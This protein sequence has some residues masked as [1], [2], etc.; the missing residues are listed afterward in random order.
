MLIFGGSE[1][2]EGVVHALDLT[3]MKWSCLENVKYRR[4]RH[5]ANLIG[6]SIYLFGG[7]YGG[8]EGGH[9][10]GYSNDLHKYDVNNQPLQIAKRRGSPS[11]RY[12]HGSTVIEDNL[13]IFG[14][15][16]Y[17][18]RLRDSTLYCMNTIS[19]EWV[20]IPIAESSDSLPQPRHFM[21]MFSF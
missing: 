3:T 1:N 21:S 12:F 19:S 18:L 7:C 9:I 11:A 17:G 8:F 2:S 15:Y 6:N 4:W 5:T 13:F 16:G 20:S 10:G 14:E